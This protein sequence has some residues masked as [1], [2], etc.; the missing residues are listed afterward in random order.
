MA[1]KKLKIV[2]AA[3]RVC[4]L[5]IALQQN[6]LIRKDFLLRNGLEVKIEKL[7]C[8]CIDL[9]QKIANYRFITNSSAEVQI[10]TNNT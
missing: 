6:I 4:T 9:L 8:Q 2:L 7:R 1:K 5:F 10:Q 3:V